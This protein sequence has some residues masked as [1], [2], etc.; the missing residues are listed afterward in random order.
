[1]RSGDPRPVATDVEACEQG[2]L[3]SDVKG[4]L[5]FTLAKTRIRNPFTCVVIP[6][7]VIDKTVSVRQM[8][9]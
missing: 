3:A 2:I 5:G 7:E 9:D 6:A 4:R 8:L 1:M